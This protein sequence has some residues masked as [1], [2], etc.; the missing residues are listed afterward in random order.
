MSKIQTPAWI[1][2]PATKIINSRPSSVEERVVIEQ[3]L[4]IYLNSQEFVTMVCSPGNERELIIGFLLSEGVLS[5][6]TD[7]LSLSFDATKGEAWVET[8]SKENLGE[9]LF[10]KRYLTSCC[11]KGRSLFYFANDARTTRYNTA[12]LEVSPEQV[13]RYAAALEE[14][15][16]LFRSTGGVHSGALFLGDCIQFYAYDI[17]RHNV[18]DKLSGLAFQ[19]GRDLSEM[20]LVFS[21][22]ISSEILIKTSKMGCPIIIGRSAPTDLALSIAQELGITVIGFARQESMNIYTHQARILTNTPSGKV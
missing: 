6:P 2:V 13:N 11:G 20:A 1:S 9:K 7:L 21:G 19:D 3:A 17:G 18:L 5:K 22:R 12:V 4:T 16:E 10:L 8:S 14:N 15:S